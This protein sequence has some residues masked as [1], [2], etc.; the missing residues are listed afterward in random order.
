MKINEKN[1]IILMA[2]IAFLM[3]GLVVTSERYIK[4]A[5][6]YDRVL[7]DNERLEKEKEDFRVKLVE[8]YK[9]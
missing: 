6:A 1:M 7:K 4:V 8:E 5:N 3:V 2:I 9:K